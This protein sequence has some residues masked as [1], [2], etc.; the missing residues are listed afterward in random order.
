MLPIIVQYLPRD[1]ERMGLREVEMAGRLGLTLAEYRAL[2]AGEL[3]ITFD[4]YERIVE[5]CG[6]AALVS[7]ARGRLERVAHD[8]P[9]QRSAGLELVEQLHSRG[10]HRI[11]AVAL[12]LFGAHLVGAPEV[13]QELGLQPHR[14]R[15]QG[16]GEVGS[17]RIHGARHLTR[18]HTL[19]HTPVAY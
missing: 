1:R 15:L 17:G 6:M 11:G 5:L 4:L 14:E 2:E 10:H 7:R 9:H 3:H 19:G 16:L 13:A 12:S 8:L 18:G